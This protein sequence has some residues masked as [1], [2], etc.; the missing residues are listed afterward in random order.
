LAKGSYYDLVTH[1]VLDV[2]V[3][4]EVELAEIYDVG[5]PDYGARGISS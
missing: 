4:D 3:D 5:T 1:P 2:V